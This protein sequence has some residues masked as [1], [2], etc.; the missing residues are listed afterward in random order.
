MEWTQESGH[1]P[2][3]TYLLRKVFLAVDAVGGN[4]GVIRVGLTQ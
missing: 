1:T 4:S 3:W 2:G